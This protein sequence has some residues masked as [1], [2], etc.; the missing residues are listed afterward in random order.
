MDGGLGAGRPAHE[1]RTR[2][3]AAVEVWDVGARY[4][5]LLRLRRRTGV[6]VAG[7]RVAQLVRARS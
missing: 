7:G 2:L 5:A 6:V 4:S 1:G 3:A